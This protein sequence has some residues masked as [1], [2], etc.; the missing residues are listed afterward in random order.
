M[1]VVPGRILEEAEVEIL[2]RDLELVIGYGTHSNLVSFIGICEDKDT[3]FAVFE[4]A[5]PSLKQ[6]LL[7]SRSLVHH[8]ALAETSGKFSTLREEIILHIMMGVTA[9]T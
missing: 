3:I 8:P 9:G 2:A 5:W 6:S 7:D 4:P 1:Q